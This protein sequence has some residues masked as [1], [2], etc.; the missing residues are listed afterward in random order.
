MSD[1]SADD[2]VLLRLDGDARTGL[3]LALGQLRPHAIRRRDV[4]ELYNALLAAMH[5]AGVLPTAKPLP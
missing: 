4:R 1:H 2:R 3:V 5:E